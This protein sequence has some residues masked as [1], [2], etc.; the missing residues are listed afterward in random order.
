MRPITDINFTESTIGQ[1]IND[2]FQNIQN[3]FNSIGTDSF[4]KG[5]KG[6]NVCVLEV[7]FDSD[8]YSNKY[9]INGTE[10]TINRLKEAIYSAIKGNSSDSELQPVNG[11]TWDGNL[12]GG[13]IYLLYDSK[14]G[15]EGSMTYHIIS[16]IPYTHIDKRFQNIRSDSN[17][18]NFD[19]KLDTSGIVYVDEDGIKF[20]QPFPTLYYNDI[21]IPGSNQGQSGFYWKINGEITGI[22]ADGPAGKDGKDSTW[23]VVRVET[24]YTG[25]ADYNITLV[26]DETLNNNTGGW[27]VPSQDLI[28][29]GQRVIGIIGPTN[30]S[31]NH[32]Y[33]MFFGVAIVNKN[34]Y[35]VNISQNN[36]VPNVFSDD[37]F[38]EITKSM[39]AAGRLECIEIGDDDK[40][41]NTRLFPSRIE[42]VR[43]DP[44]KV[45]G[46]VQIGASG[47][48]KLFE[49]SVATSKIISSY[50]DGGMEI[51]DADKPTAVNLYGI[52]SYAHELG[53]MSNGQLALVSAGDTNK[54]VYFSNGVPVA[55]N[56]DIGD[57][58]TPVYISGGVITTCNA[59]SA[60]EATTANNVNVGSPTNTETTGY[61]SIV[62][63]TGSKPIKMTEQIK[64]ARDNSDSDWKLQCAGGFY[65]TSDETL[66]N[67]GD[68]ISIDFEKLANLPKKHFTWKRDEEGLNP[69]I[70]TSAQAVK[71]LYPEIVSGEEG[72]YSVAYD[73]LSI[74]ALAAIDKLYE[75]NKQKDEEIQLLKQEIAAIKQ[76]INDKL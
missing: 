27:V 3:N 6:D 24:S 59:V 53:S 76:M 61:L 20:N 10:Y 75:Q 39:G 17:F 48:V 11:D 64:C 50:T 34:S 72:S 15:S 28:T 13:K 30:S 42:T 67:F 32:S 57:T 41:D 29:N 7:V 54:P 46:C 60:S 8:S 52:S 35:K 44:R 25:Q 73:K 68:D 63:S 31:G 40:N 69:Q 70:G 16:S 51:G 19:G 65:E 26:W 22:R 2:N 9:T 49:T 47:D 12:T 14:T 38:D 21:D 55:F 56:S 43:L 71:E 66:K 62:A 1:Q 18:S 74:V 33:S 4:L 23:V 36:T 45:N 5:D 58:N 37:I